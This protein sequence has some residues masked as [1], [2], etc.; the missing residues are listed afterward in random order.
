M[1]TSDVLID[2]FGRVR[3]IVHDVVDGLSVAGLEAR[4]GPEAN[5]ISWL[6]W[7]L[8]RIEDDHIADLTGAEQVWTTG[9]WMDRCGLPFDATATGFG[10]TSDDVAATRVDPPSLLL[11]YHDATHEQT[12]A[13]LETIDAEE[14][15]RI[16]DTR[17]DPPVM[18]GV[19]IVSVVADTLQHA[20]QA[21]YVRGLLGR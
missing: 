3:E 10:F 15:L 4:P 21:A 19:R 1:Q 8:T 14:L 11:G 6:V 9:G 7:H 2:A 17:W 16:V 18:A 5:S 13:Y 12:V 20:G